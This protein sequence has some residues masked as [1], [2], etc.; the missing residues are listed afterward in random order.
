MVS[1]NYFRSS[2]YWS[3]DVYAINICSYRFYEP[4]KSPIVPQSG[5]FYRR[6][7]HVLN[8]NEKLHWMHTIKKPPIELARIKAKKRKKFSFTTCFHYL[9]FFSLYPYIPLNEFWAFFHTKPV[10][11]SFIWEL[12]FFSFLFSIFICST[13][14]SS[15][16]KWWA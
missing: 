9:L 13:T 1:A 3:Y 14:H 10:I 6:W 7:R 16:K 15:L 2:F 12:F 8:F 11:N 5:I 4:V